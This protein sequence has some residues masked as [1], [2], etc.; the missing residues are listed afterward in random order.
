[1]ELRN[2]ISAATGLRLPA[3]LIF[4][5]PTA[6]AVAHHLD[7]TLA[8]TAADPPVVE[9]VARVDDD[10]IVIVAMACRYPGGV[11]SPEELW[12]LVADGVDAIAEFP[13]TRGWDGDLYHPEPGKGR[14]VL[15]PRGWVPS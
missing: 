14:E 2:E 7:E 15:R 12:R 6:L 11:A 13:T 10:P 9:T 8:G 3:T 4:D 1:M 5:Y